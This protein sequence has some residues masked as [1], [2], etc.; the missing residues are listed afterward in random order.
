MFIEL[1]DWTLFGIEGTSFGLDEKL[2]E[3]STEK[4]LVLFKFC[5]RISGA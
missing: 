2:Q 4:V 3:L 1:G 5:Y